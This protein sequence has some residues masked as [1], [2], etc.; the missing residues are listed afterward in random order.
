MTQLPHLLNRTRISPQ[1]QRVFRSNA[2]KQV[3]HLSLCLIF[4]LLQNKLPQ[5][6]HLKRTR[7]YYL[8]ISINLAQHG[9]I[10]WLGSQW[11]SVKVLAR[12]GTSLSEASME[13]FTPGSFTLSAEFGSLGLQDW[14]PRF[15]AVGQV[16]ALLLGSLA[17]LFL[18]LPSSSSHQVIKFQVI[19][20]S[21]HFSSLRLFPFCFHR[22]HRNHSDKQKN[23]PFL[24]SAK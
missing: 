22:L 12:L 5:T 15:L 7:M 23:L 18:W 1:D 11:A 3:M 20:S 6:K 21:L 19:K 14:G 17:F 2:I 16:C 13:E 24:R 9:W 8:S 4:Q 10:L